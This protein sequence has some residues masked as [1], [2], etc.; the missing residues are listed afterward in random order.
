MVSIY[1]KTR[2]RNNPEDHD[3]NTPPSWKPHIYVINLALLLFSSYDKQYSL[4]STEA[5]ISLTVF[6]LSA[7]NLQDMKLKE[8]DHK[9]KAKVDCTCRISPCCAG[10]MPRQVCS[11]FLPLFLVVFSLC[12]PSTWIAAQPIYDAGFIKL[13]RAFTTQNA[14]RFWCR[15]E[16]FLRV[17]NKCCCSKYTLPF[18][19]FLQNSIFI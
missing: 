7:Q 17:Y 8:C 4:L 15:L 3:M 16:T 6:L 12:T 9:C 11:L 13:F 10:V 14:V 2:C 19:N 18:L 1:K 5:F